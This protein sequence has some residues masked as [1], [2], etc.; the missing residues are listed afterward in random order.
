M[1]SLRRAAQRPRGPLHPEILSRRPPR[2]DAK[3]PS[4]WLKRHAVVTAQLHTLSV[5]QVLFIPSDSPG[6][7]AGAFLFDTRKS[8]QRNDRS[9][10]LSPVSYPQSL[11]PGSKP[12]LSF[13]LQL[14]ASNAGVKEKARQYIRAGQ[15]R[16]YGL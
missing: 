8:R 11:A 1:P 16:R 10:E 4:P 12:G 3:G 6:F 2:R 9:A 5:T 15:V 7:P 13:G 14:A